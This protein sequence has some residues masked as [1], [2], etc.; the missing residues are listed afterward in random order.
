MFQSLQF[1]GQDIVVWLILGLVI[2]VLLNYIWR[3]LL[4]LRNIA[5]KKPESCTSCQNCPSSVHSCAK[6][7]NQLES[8]D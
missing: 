4:A 3:R 6:A 1:T 8:E 7:E 2:F 5:K